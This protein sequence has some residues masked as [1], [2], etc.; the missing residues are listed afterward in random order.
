M[1]AFHKRPIDQDV[2]ARKQPVG[3][4]RMLGSG[5]Y[6]LERIA[7]E[8]PYGL[9]GKAALGLLDEID[10]SALVLRFHGLA[11]EQRQPIDVGRLQTG[12]NLFGNTG[13]ER[14]AGVEI[15]RLPVEATLATPSTARHEQCGSHPFAIGDVA[16]FHIREIHAIARLKVKDPVADL[17]GTALVPELSAD[18]SARTARDVEFLLVAVTAVGAFP[19][20]LAVIFDDANLP[21]ETAN[22]AIIALRIELRVHDVV[23]DVLDD[24]DDRRKVVLHIRNFDI[25]DGTARGKTLEGAFE[26]QLGERIDLLGDVDMVAVGDVALV[27]NAFDDTEAALEALGE[28]VGGGLKRRAVQREIDVVLCFPFCALV[29][30]VLHDGHGEGSSLGIGVAFARHVL[31]ALVQTGI[32]Q[33]DGGIAPVE[34][35]VD[36]FAL[37]QTRK[38]T[39]LPK[40]GGCIGQRALQAVVTTHEGT[41]AQLEAFVEDLPERIHVTFRRAGDIDQIDG[42]DA[43]VEAAVVLRLALIVDVRS[44]EAPATHGGI[45]VAFA[46]F[47]HLELEHDLLGH[48]IGHHAL[49]RALGGKL[50]QVEIR[51]AFGDVVLLEDIDQLGECRRD[52]Y[53]LFVLDATM[54]LAQHLFDDHGKIALLGLA[55]G[56]VE[57]HEHGDEGSL[58]VGGQ[59][60]NDLVL[61]GLDAATDLVAQTL[62]DDGVKL[63]GGGLDP[64]AV[65][66]GE[67]IAAD[68]LAAHIHEG[69]Q[70]RKGDGLTAVLVA[71]N[72]RDDLGGDVAGSGEAMRRLDQ[73]TGDDGAVLEHVLKIDQV[74]VVHV[75]GEIIRIMEMDQAVFM[76]LDNIL[77]KQ[78]AHGQVLGDLTG[79]VIALNGIDR[80]VLVGI[81]LLDLF[82]VALDKRQNLIVCGV[83][84]ALEA[85]NV[86]VD[87]VLACDR[88]AAGGHDAVFHHVLDLF[89]RNGMPARLALL[90]NLTRGIQNLR[91]GE[92]LRCRNLLVGTLDGVDDLLYIEDGF[93]S[94]SLDDLHVNNP[95]RTGEQQA[96][97]N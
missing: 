40:D 81:L 92:L 27:R 72:L 71:G 28:L 97:D 43:L 85:L 54:A 25:R 37:L 23:V 75:L 95:I 52:P 4:L 20:Q 8:A 83:G 18:V 74:A 6:L 45:A 69:R 91:I 68:L 70:M 36:D 11:A 38:G 96:P 3:H 63:I 7:R 33:A 47:I 87:D 46:V 62:L 55:A 1:E 57:V 53:A 51:R 31:A 39:V 73:R 82:V 77:R 19:N 65:E 90:G 59:Q 50:G 41:V 17:L 14:L 12:E 48:V 60:G 84:D 35:R 42:D 21:I 67:D 30:H 9:F 58:A 56:L 13:I 80:G 86:A 79:H 64:D 5:N 26:L 49:R 15:P 89:D 22:L 94:A 66:F 76:R 29:I 10:Q 93:R 16:I 44:Q 24:A 78:H 88:E 34:E 2:D 32:S 61:D